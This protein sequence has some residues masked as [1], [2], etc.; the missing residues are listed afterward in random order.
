M[1]ISKKGGEKMPTNTVIPD[2][3]LEAR[4]HH[5]KLVWLYVG[6]QL[7][8]TLLLSPSYVDHTVMW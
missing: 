1:A 4:E 2:D 8:L 3:D 6:A 7:L 5:V